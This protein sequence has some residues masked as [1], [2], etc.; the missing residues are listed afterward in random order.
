MK[1]SSRERHERTSGERV[2]KLFEL[3]ERVFDDNPERSKRYI[4]LMRKVAM[5]FNVRIP[6]DIRRRFCS[7]CHAVLVFGRNARMR[8]NKR[9][10]S[11]IVTCLECGNVMRY[12]YKKEKQLIKERT[13]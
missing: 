5:R 12:P 8:T 4:C 10:Q 7:R 1:N 6:K 9:Q 2:R 3:A 13:K 11:V